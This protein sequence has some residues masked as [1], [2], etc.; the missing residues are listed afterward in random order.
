M[1]T[2]PKTVIRTWS[3]VA[4]LSMGFNIMTSQQSLNRPYTQTFETTKLWKSGLFL[5]ILS[6][7]YTFIILATIHLGLYWILS[8]RD[9]SGWIKQKILKSHKCLTMFPW[10]L[11]ES[12]MTHDCAILV[13]AQYRQDITVGQLCCICDKLGWIWVN[14]GV[15]WY[16]DSTRTPRNDHE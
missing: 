9:A 7:S 16:P 11:Y 3:N 10:C 14:L 8:N 13:L 1:A 12:I 4:H 15:S 2:Q 5:K 6:L